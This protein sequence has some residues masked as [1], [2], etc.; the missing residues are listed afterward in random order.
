MSCRPLRSTV[1]VAVLASFS[2]WL[3]CRHLYLVPCH[4][5]TCP[6]CLTTP[7]PNTVTA[8]TEGVPAE[9]KPEACAE[10][11]TPACNCPVAD[12]QPTA[13]V[14]TARSQ[15]WP[16]QSRPLQHV[17]PERRKVYTKQRESFGLQTYEFQTVKCKRTRPLSELVAVVAILLLSPARDA[18]V[19]VRTRAERLSGFYRG[20]D[21]HIVTDA[22]APLASSPTVP[23]LTFHSLKGSLGQALSKIA[24]TVSTPFLLMGHDLTAEGDRRDVDLTRLVRIADRYDAAAVGGSMRDAGGYWH[25]PCVQS[26]L[27]RYTLR[28]RYGYDHSVDDCL[29]CDA[30]HGPFLMPTDTLKARV[31]ASLHLDAAEDLFL[32][33]FSERTGAAPPHPVLVCPDI[34][35]PVD[36]DPDGAAA[37]AAFASLAAKWG[38]SRWILPSS[39]ELWFGCAGPGPGVAPTDWTVTGGPHAAFGNESGLTVQQVLDRGMAITPC[40]EIALAGYVHATLEACA[41]VGAECAVH[42]GI[43]LGALK[44]RGVL[45]WDN[46]GDV[47]YREARKRGKASSQEAE[48]TMRA[49]L[50]PHGL[51]LR[52]KRG[53]PYRLFETRNGTA[54]H[55]FTVDLHYPN[56]R[57][58][59]EE[60]P[61]GFTRIFFAGRWVNVSYNPARYYREYYG[62]GIFRH[63][64]LPV[65]TKNKGAY[66]RCT[67]PVERYR[68]GCADAFASDGS[69]QFWD[70]QVHV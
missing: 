7:R 24:A 62:G 65:Y 21:V 42:S 68:H 56:R 27:R 63:V 38:L 47:A 10:T 33:L 70:W 52:F 4:I 59:A 51:M 41:A 15:A 25:L 18:A 58:Q 43:A 60:W 48:E 67:P 40:A 14:G 44:M 12:P 55:G 8:P 50:L 49:R 64:M 53:V 22:T 16:L 37:A 54:R 11:E 6:S 9:T 39:R 1:A 32:Q 69:R 2:T 19:P 61:R 23:K 34:M 5:Q 29:V 3:L 28:Q 66:A 36:G 31:D 26:A 30:I 20:L 57:E 17:C 46:D 35:F 45:P 13:D